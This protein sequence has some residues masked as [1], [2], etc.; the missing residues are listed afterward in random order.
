MGRKREEKIG[1]Y[2]KICTVRGKKR[3]RETYLN[4]LDSTAIRERERAH[5]KIN[6]KR[7]RGERKLYKIP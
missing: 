2:I 5:K 6:K 4:Y 1:Y 7:K 3:E